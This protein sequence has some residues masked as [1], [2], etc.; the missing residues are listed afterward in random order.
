V[1]FRLAPVGSTAGAFLC[2]FFQISPE[3]TPFS[4]P[5]KRALDFCN[6]M[7]DSMS[8]IGDTIMDAYIKPQLLVLIPLLIG[9]GKAIKP[10][11]KKRSDGSTGRLIPILLLCTS[12]AVATVYGFIAT[13]Y[14]GWRMVL[15]S[16]VITGIVQGSIAAFSAMG[17]YDTTRK[18]E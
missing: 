8:M 3:S 15:D 13:P 5:V 17:L 14:T 10:S 6:G 9:M 11:L 1:L 7:F 16:V 18:K 4:N 12:I 2:I